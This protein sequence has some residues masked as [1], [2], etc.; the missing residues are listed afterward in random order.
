MK[1]D[2]NLADFIRIHD[3][4]NIRKGFALF[5]H[6][7]GEISTEKKNRKQYFIKVPS[8]SSKGS[9][10]VSL[11]VL[12]DNI[13]D[14]C[15]CKAYEKYGEC[16]HTV[17]AALYLLM[18]EFHYD[19]DELEELIDIDDFDEELEFIEM[20]RSAVKTKR[21]NVK[22]KV[23]SMEEPP[24]TEWKKF[25]LK[26]IMTQ[27]SLDNLSGYYWTSYND[28]D[29]LS[30]TS[31]DEKERHWMFAYNHTAKQVFVP[32]IKYD[33][34]ITYYYRCN[35]NHTG[36]YPMCH[37]VQVAFDMLINQKGP[38]YFLQF[39]DWT[40]EKN[41]LLKPY[42][43]TTLDDDAKLFQFSMSYSGELLMQAP[44]AY[45]R[46]G[47]KGQ[48]KKLHH[49]LK[50]KNDIALPVVT[51]PRPV[52]GTI[53]D[54]ETGFVF[55]LTSQR[56]K[57][58]FEL[59]PVK[60]YRK[61][62]RTD[63][64]KLSLNQA[65]NLPLLN[66][67]NDDV[68]SLLLQLSDTQ[69]LNY[70]EAQGHNYFSNYSNPWQQI[71]DTTL[72]ILKRHYTA[73]LQKLWPYLSDQPHVFLLKDGKFSSANCKPVQVSKDTVELSFRATTDDRFIT[74]S[75]T[76]TINSNI[77]FANTVTLMQGFIFNIDNTLHIIKNSEDLPV[78]EQFSN[79]FIKIP[80]FRKA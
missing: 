18:D 57:S 31:F 79:G 37:H 50:P 56:L 36:R 80:G 27:N 12:T 14:N 4:S 55:N 9:Y 3:E 1:A 47:D 34:G 68:Y 5:A 58:G 13:E 25:E 15:E 60:V 24:N 28:F 43:L 30:Q 78:L 35:C 17:A 51:R 75:L 61:Q 33:G 41:N 71:S 49:L 46:S 52:P 62:E 45:M 77:V 38:G 67:L 10:T 70:L 11:K 19:I 20:K 66:E 53:I 39:K 32:E 48:L 8:Q 40:V 29:K 6:N 69:L 16:K 23:I 64:K 73:C 76:P 22:A 21:K 63:L 2:E 26:G 74:I 59:E 54:F 65:A 7:M 44:A 42:G 72:E